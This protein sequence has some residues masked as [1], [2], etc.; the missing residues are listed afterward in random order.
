MSLSIHLALPL[1][2]A[3]FSILIAVTTNGATDPLHLA[4]KHL[5]RGVT[6]ERRQAAKQLGQI[7][8]QLAVQ[9]LARAL[10]DADQLVREIAEQ[11]LWQ[12]WL[13]S[14]Q[15]NVDT[16]LSEGILAMQRGAL[17][18]AVEIFSDVIEMAPDF[19]EAYNK[20]ATA[21]YL[22]QEYEKSIRDCD[23]TIILNP[24]HFGALSGAGL[25]YLGLH[26]PLKA[27]EFFERAV[28]VNPNMPQIQQ[29]IKAIK[30]FLRDETL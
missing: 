24:V 15:T 1:L 19:A 9:P 28:A 6:L 21:Y 11:S 20:R 23:S 22:L 2:V 29:Y 7:G 5:Q 13:R 27:L 12:I 14:G 10:H 25:N 30:D 17:Q 8:N 16:R 3:S 18:L 26:N 4:L